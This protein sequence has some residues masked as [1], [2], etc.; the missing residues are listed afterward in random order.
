[1]KYI[2]EKGCAILN[3]ADSNNIINAVVEEGIYGTTLGLLDKEQRTV[4][5][6][7]GYKVSAIMFGEAK[8]EAVEANNYS[9]RTSV[10]TTYSKN[11]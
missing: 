10:T 7:K 8:E 1:M 4:H 6:S 3:E 2:A 9:S 11:C 5:T